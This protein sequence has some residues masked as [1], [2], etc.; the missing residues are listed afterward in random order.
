[1]QTVILVATLFGSQELGIS[2]TKLIITIIIIQILGIAGSS[3]FAEVST[4][5]GNKFSLSLML[6][7]WISVCIAAYFINSEIEFFI[8]AAAVVW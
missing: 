5:K 6:L 3:L 2:G 8:L 7:I 4:R 1:V